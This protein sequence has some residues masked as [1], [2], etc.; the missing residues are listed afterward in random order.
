M[1]VLITG[2]A[3]CG[4]SHYA[5]DIFN[6]FIGK[7]Y[8]IATMQ[9]DGEEAQATIARHRAQREGK[10]FVTIEQYFDFT[11]VCVPEGSGMLLECL[12]NLCANVLFGS[13]PKD[14]Q[15]S[16]CNGIR[17]LSEHAERLVIVTNQVGSDG[18]DY[19]EGTMRYMKLIGEINRYA[20]SLADV[21]VECVYGIPV[22]RKGIPLW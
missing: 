6:G 10:G 22:I 2:G 19:A 3:K 9:P 16:I 17:Y 20:A 15:E 11:E 18:I 5:E 4:K 1:T 12:G 21:V 8:Y 13:H 14:T 7:K